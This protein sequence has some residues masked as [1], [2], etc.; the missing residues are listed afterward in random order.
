MAS[1]PQREQ[2]LLFWFPMFQASPIVQGFSFLVNFTSKTQSKLSKSQE[3]LFPTRATAKVHPIHSV[4]L[5]LSSAA[6]HNLIIL[7]WAWRTFSSTEKTSWEENQ[8][9]CK[10]SRPRPAIHLYHER[11]WPSSIW[12]SSEECRHRQKADY[13]LSLLTTQNGE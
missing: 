2:L 12:K 9:G 7:F 8:W 10:S 4:S 3:D 5:I 1:G 6:A 13:F 11:I